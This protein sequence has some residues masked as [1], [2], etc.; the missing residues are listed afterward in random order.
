MFTEFVCTHYL[1]LL[2][3]EHGTTACVTAYEQQK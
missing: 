2:E 3:K 1:R